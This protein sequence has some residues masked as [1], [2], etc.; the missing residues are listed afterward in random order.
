MLLPIVNREL[1]VA[2]RNKATYRLRL[3]FAVGAVTIGG[4]LGLLSMIRGGLPGSQLGIWMFA[5]LKWI[6]FI[7]ACAAGVFLTSDSLSEEKREGTLGLLF[8]TDLRG[9]DVVLGKLLATSLRTFYSLLAIFPVMAFSF[10][11]GGVAA[12][13]FRHTLLALCNALFFSL[14]LGMAISVISRD[15]NKAMTGAMA[16]MVVFL[17]LI[18]GLD[19][20]LPGGKAGFPF[21]GLLSPA[22]AFRHTISYR[23]SEFW[24]SII[25]VQLAGWCFLAIASWLAPKTWQDKAVRYIP[26]TGWQFRLLGRAAAGSSRQKLLDQNPVCWLIARD[27]WAA[28]LARLAILLILGVFALSLASIFLSRGPTAAVPGST[29]T[30]TNSTTTTLMTS[31]NGT[32]SGVVIVS[33]SSG[34]ASVMAG[35][36]WYMLAR[37]CASVLSLALEFWLAA[38]VCRFYIDGKRSGFLELLLVTPVTQAD[39]LKGHW[40]ALRRL[41]LPPVAAQLLLTLVF[42]A[43]QL[44]AASSVAVAASPAGTTIPPTVNH[45][46]E[47][48][49]VIALALGTISWCVGLFTI[50]WFSIWMGLTSKKIPIAMLKTFWYAKILPWFGI[51]FASVFL[52]IPASISLG[53]IS[54]W[55]SPMILYLLFIG[56]NLALIERAR[57]RAREAFAQWANSAV[58]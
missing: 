7:F 46:I 52:M 1:R 45:S 21:F 3:F 12:E 36:G 40:L 42:G 33:S 13:D 17:F 20:L 48:A 43:I 22:Y 10:V 57:R 32:R 19:S 58:V 35:N 47:I 26:R 5:A 16:A 31:T 28:N 29:A 53:S 49:Q 55:L 23:A 39:I 24:V 41:F 34:G 44:W 56:V 2:A 14:A 50:V 54:I 6:A 51:S 9:H 11:L 30:V 15:S 27:R 25:F 38:H 37:S 4:G 18:P 8:L